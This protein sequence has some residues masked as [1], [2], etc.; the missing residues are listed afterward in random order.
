ML[1][2]G[3][4][5]ALTLGFALPPQG[6]TWDISLD[7]A[8]SEACGVAIG[9]LV[10]EDGVVGPPGAACN[11]TTPP[12]QQWPAQLRSMVAHDHPNVVALLAG[13]WEITDR[14]YRGQWTNITQPAFRAYVERQLNLAIHIGTSS[15]AHM[16]LLTAPCF[17][18]GE[19]PDGSPWPEDTASRLAAYNSSVRDVAAQNRA[20]TSVVDLHAM[21]C[22]GG[23]YHSLLDGVTVRAPDGVHFP[24]Y[25]LGQAD[26]A[27]P[28]TRAQADAF[29]RWMAPRLIPELV[30]RGSS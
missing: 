19:Q 5:T 13:R 15:G 16:V 9:P 25:H 24:Y 3:D 30:A 17:A 1:L 28:D 26:A 22:P 2:V 10:K 11:S 6:P 21:V 23:T 12:A 29:G 14:L 20:T 4:S 27:A 8:G 18:S 7:N